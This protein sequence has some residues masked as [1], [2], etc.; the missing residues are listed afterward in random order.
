MSQWVRLSRVAETLGVSTRT[1]RRWAS[2][3]LQVHRIGR[4]PYTTWA[5]VAD[6][7]RPLQE[8]QD[9]IPARGTGRYRKQLEEARQ[10][11]TSD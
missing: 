8:R 5:A 3:G 10:D 7:A 6:F 2:Q 1:V 11:A 4:T 9:R